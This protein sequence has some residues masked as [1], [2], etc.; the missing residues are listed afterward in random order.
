MIMKINRIWILDY[1][2]PVWPRGTVYSPHA[3]FEPYSRVAMQSSLSLI[4]RYILHNSEYSSKVTLSLSFLF[5]SWWSLFHPLSLRR[6]KRYSNSFNAIIKVDTEQRKNDGRE[7]KWK[8]LRCKGRIHF[9]RRSATTW[10]TRICPRR[11]MNRSHISD[12]HEIIL[13]GSS[14]E[15]F[16]F[17]GRGV[18]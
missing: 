13:D 12:H 16:N 3:S 5:L 4:P 11:F 18:C 1:S 10:M 17:Y 15:G 14:S 7:S 2:V 8:L 9:E 6:L